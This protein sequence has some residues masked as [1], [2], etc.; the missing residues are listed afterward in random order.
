MLRQT[1]TKKVAV[2]IKTKNQKMGPSLTVLKLVSFI[3]IQKP[4]SR[5]D[6]MCDLI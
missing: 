5:F 2:N 6:V 3:L 1:N 4:T